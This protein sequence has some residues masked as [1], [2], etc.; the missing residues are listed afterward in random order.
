M[1]AHF[2]DRPSLLIVDDDARIRELT[3]FAARESHL[4]SI[5]RTAQDG[6]DALDMLA[7]GEPLPDVVLT[8]L[9]M[10]RMDGFELV[11]TLKELPETREIPVVMF[12]SSGLHFD[13][14]HALAV[15]CEAFHLKP[16]SLAGLNDVICA[17]AASARHACRG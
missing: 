4:F 16:T 2:E 5:I 1:P 15:G 10:P 14:E 7:D 9:S 12:S 17:V 3:E 11:R 8:D 13:R 6:A